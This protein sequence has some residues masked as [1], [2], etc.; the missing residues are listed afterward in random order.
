MRTELPDSK[1]VEIIAGI[2]NQAQSVGAAAQQP[3]QHTFAP[4]PS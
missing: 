2:L 4:H 3:L 1:K